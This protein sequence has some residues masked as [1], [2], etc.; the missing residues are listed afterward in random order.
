MASVYKFV[1]FGRTTIN[2]P[3]REPRNIK[4]WNPN[5]TQH[6][7]EEFSQVRC[8]CEHATTMT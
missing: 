6:A 5:R 3:N 4:K 2:N 1:Q 7:L 8:G